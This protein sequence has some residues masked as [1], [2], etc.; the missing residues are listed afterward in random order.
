MISNACLAEL[1][2]LAFAKHLVCFDS[3]YAAMHT[4]VR[5][6]AWGTCTCHNLNSLPRAQAQGKMY[7]AWAKSAPVMRGSKSEGS[8]TWPTCSQCLKHSSPQGSAL[9]RLCT[10][11]HLIQQN[12]CPSIAF[13]TKSLFIGS[14]G[15]V[16][17]S[18][19]PMPCAQTLN[20]MRQ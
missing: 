20:A 6:F 10:G 13:S 15:Y 9:H 2:A 5:Y 11:A 14:C 18:S 3:I 12:S 7:E 8:A 16:C 4:N 17:R 19:S 1:I